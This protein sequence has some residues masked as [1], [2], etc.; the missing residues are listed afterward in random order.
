M[1]NDAA[2]THNGILLSHEEGWNDAI[3]CTW[4]H[5]ESVILGEVSQREK[6]K[7]RMMVFAYVWNLKTRYKH[8]S[9]HNRFLL[10][11][12]DTENT[13]VVSGGRGQDKLGD[14]HW[15]IH[16]TYMKER[17]CNTSPQ[18]PGSLAPHS[19]A[20]RVGGDPESVGMCVTGSLRCAAEANTTL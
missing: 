2:H 8:T 17:A 13:P 12:T 20:A 5:L 4:M 7:Y 16:T 11:A 14:W 18:S 6:D 10:W 19:G 9:L 1:G 3:S 15:H